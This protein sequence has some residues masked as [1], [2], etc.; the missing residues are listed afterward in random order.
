M[1]VSLDDA[2]Q[3][4]G[5]EV[6][7]AL[8]D[9]RLGLILQGVKAQVDRFC[10]TPLVAATH[11]QRFDGGEHAWFLDRRPITEITSI[12][13]PAGNAIASTEYLL[14]E[15]LGMIEF[16]GYAPRAVRS[17]GER[18][19]WEVIYKAGHFATEGAVTGDAANAILDLVSDYYH[20]AGPD[21]Q[22][23]RVGI[24]NVVAFIPN[25]NSRFVLPPR[26]QVALAPYVRRTM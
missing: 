10:G 8:D 14:R 4:L 6:G 9:H 11:K 22:S 26:V 1:G 25:P 7:N 16:Y 15:E 5:L 19:R 24:E 12:L 17:T 20:K 23:Q 13:D 2:K 3:W 21:V 18:D